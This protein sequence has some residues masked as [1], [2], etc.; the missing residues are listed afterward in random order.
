MVEDTI[1]LLTGAGMKPVHVKADVPVY[2]GN[3]MQHALKREAIALVANGVCSAETVDAVVRYGFGRR[4]ALVGLLEQADLGGTV[5]TIAIHEILMPDID[6]TPVPHPYLAAMVER[7]DLGAKSGRGFH[8]WALGKAE[9]CRAKI[10]PGLVDQL[11]PREGTIGMSAA[12]SDAE[13]SD[14]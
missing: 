2:V 8:S 5:L 3:R 9:R 12:D 6:V 10:N 13:G 4:L 14:E 1:K 11:P 7:G